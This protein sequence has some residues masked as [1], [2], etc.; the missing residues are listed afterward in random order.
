MRWFLEE[1]AEQ[2]SIPLGEITTAL[3][4]QAKAKELIRLASSFDT[5]AFGLYYLPHHFRSP[6]APFHYTV[7]QRLAK[8]HYYA[9]AAPRGHAKSTLIA[10]AHPLLEAAT[11]RARFIILIGADGS[12]AE[13]RLEDILN[14]LAENETLLEAYPHLRPPDPVELRKWAKQRKRFKQKRSD[15]MTIGGTRFS[16]RGAGQALRG[17]KQGAQ[18]PD[19]IILDDV[20]TDKRCDSTRQLIKLSRWFDT[21]VMNL[22]G[23]E[24]ARIRVA[25]TKL[26]RRALIARLIERWGG[27]VFKA[28][29]DEEKQKT[30]WPSVW[31]YDRLI[32]KRDGGIEEDGTEIEGIGPRRFAR[33]Y[34]NDPAPEDETF[35]TEGQ[36]TT[37]DVP[38]SGYPK[39]GF[40]TA[41]LD[42]AVGMSEKS[43]QN[44][45]VLIW[46]SPA[47]VS[48]IIAAERWRGVAGLEERVKR[49]LNENAQEA[50]RLIAVEAVQYQ[51]KAV[52]DLTSAMPY[53]FVPVHPDRSKAARF[54]LIADRFV[55]AQII[56]LQGLPKWYQEELLSFPIGDGTWD[57]IDATVYAYLGK[58]EKGQ[59]RRMRTAII[60][61]GGGGDW[62]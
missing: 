55:G 6:P 10:L 8:R 32:M 33:E 35:L 4:D 5:V 29:I 19:L 15:F 57:G 44:A 58:F 20:D 49:F 7:S 28:I 45:I 39:K 13:D 24:K 51:M 31:P 30:L 1:L 42:L 59:R 17:M 60:P 9:V 22:E 56:L 25:G 36:L 46:H 43:S 16:A 40:Y 2:R 48:Y 21:V 23:V 38:P 41:G 3:E 61:T 34:L 11:G 53:R 50:P 47:N 62:R 52:L 14:E 12:S 26:C 27:D 54:A 18:R 37:V